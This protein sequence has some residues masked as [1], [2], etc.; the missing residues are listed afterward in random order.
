[1]NDTS[2]MQ[3]PPGQT[4][5]APNQSFINQSFVLTSSPTEV[6]S[7]GVCCLDEDLKPMESEDF[8]D[9]KGSMM[10]QDIS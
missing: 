4:T 3:N 10:F 6:P 5:F 7:I 2:D 9:T 8:L 1:M